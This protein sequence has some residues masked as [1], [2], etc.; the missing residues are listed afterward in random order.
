MNQRHPLAG[1]T[2]TAA[3]ERGACAQKVDLC[4]GEVDYKLEKMERPKDKDEGE[5]E[6]ESAR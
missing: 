6:P 3:P 2:E 4:R 1:D 5:R